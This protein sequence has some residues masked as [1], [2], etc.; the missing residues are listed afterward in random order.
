MA[1]K[2]NHAQTLVSLPAEGVSSE[3]HA[4]LASLAFQE[5]RVTQLL[6]SRQEI[7]SLRAQYEERLLQVATQLTQLTVSLPREFHP[8]RER[9]SPRRTAR[10]RKTLDFCPRSVRS[11][12]P[13]EVERAVDETPGAVAS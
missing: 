12:S 10:G 1:G 6:S 4:H 2:S 11:A 7:E 9:R 3:E 8:E 5:S 13:A